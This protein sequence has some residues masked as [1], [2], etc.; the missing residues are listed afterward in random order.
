ME[1]LV[2][3]RETWFNG[4]VTD[5]PRR[6]QRSLRHNSRFQNLD[7]PPPCDRRAAVC[8]WMLRLC[9]SGEMIRPPYLSV[10][11]HI[12]LF[13]PILQTKHRWRP[14]DAR[15]MTVLLLDLRRR[16]YSQHLNYIRDCPVWQMVSFIATTRRQAQTYYL[17][18]RRP[19]HPRRRPHPD[20]LPL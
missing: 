19:L 5:R 13:I 18:P 14:S 7:L 2:I 1:D 12:D 6:L 8:R 16:R 15:A 20:P 9:S 17:R 4:D 10:P 3:N 11:T